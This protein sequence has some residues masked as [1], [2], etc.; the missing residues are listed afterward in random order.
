MELPTFEKNPQ[1]PLRLLSLDGGG[2]RGLSSLMVLRD[3]MQSIALEEKRLGRRAQ[4]D[5]EA[6]RPCDYFD[7]IGGTSTGGI[8]AILLSRLR[9]NCEQCIDIYLKLAQQI[10]EHDRS[11]KAFGMKV[12]TGATRFSGAILA[13]AIKNSLKGLGFNEN[14]LMWDEALFEEVEDRPDLTNNS[15]WADAAPDLVITESPVVTVKND[16]EALP[17][18]PPTSRSANASR[19]ET[20]Y[21][22]SPFSPKPLP[23]RSDTWKL[24]PRQSVHRKANAAGCRG[25]VLTSLKNVGLP[26]ILST[27][28]P[29]DR[30][31]RIWEALRAT[32]A[33]PTFFEEMQFGTPKV[34]YLDGGVGFNN[35]C[36]EV[37]YAAKA[38][39]EGRSIGL[40]LSIGTGLQ[41]L[42]SVKKMPTWLPFGLGTDISLATALAGMA[43]STA[44]VDNEM[45]R[46]YNNSGT[47]YYRFDVDR[48]LANIS[49]EQWMKEDE[50]AS[51]TE[52]YMQDGEQVRRAKEFGEIV[53]KLSALPPKFEIAP[54]RFRVGIDG[55]SLRDDSFRLVQVDFKT[56]MLLG[57]ASHLEDLPRM[58]QFRSSSPSGEGGLAV[59]ETGGLRKIYP[60]AEDL[61]HDGRREEAAVYQCIKADNICIRDIKTGIPPGKYKVQFIVAFHDATYAPPRDLV[62]SVGRPFDASTF[63]SRFVD[64][65][66]TPDVA[67]VLLHPDAV[68]VR[69]GKKRYEE[70]KGKGW[71]EIEGD[72]EINVGLDGAL[73][74]IV[75]KRFQEEVFI[76]G[77]S[78]GGVRLEP[79]FGTQPV[80]SPRIWT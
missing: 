10:F 25:F 64:V 30:T 37:D 3:L 54:T 74:F 38:L 4:G 45:R 68:R 35:P 28:D 24:H 34:T 57:V 12:P 32:S 7:L 9:L 55:N 58:S 16:E 48:G 63:K 39:W 46:M 43:T 29:N 77:W 52:Q 1:A 14:E 22:D 27:Y 61:D 40:I 78:F 67:A 19:P 2:V 51:L 65:K 70:N 72:I 47:K 6:L 5:H 20:L 75:S 60:V 13:N 31:T 80:S 56:G 69:V 66:I 44:R 59:D 23:P 15:I 71:I 36:A 50:M 11:F 49:L 41:S 21:S 76:D 8:I 33:A 42:S 17:S 26:R 18:G 73:G 79:V 53:A 62:F